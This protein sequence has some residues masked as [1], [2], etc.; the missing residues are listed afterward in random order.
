MG[1]RG[2]TTM[3]S[4]L[5]PLESWLRSLIREE[6]QAAMGQ[7]GNTGP[8]HPEATKPYF[9]VRQ[10][11]QFSCLGESTIRLAISKRELKAHK[12][13]ERVIIKRIDLERFL[14]SNPIE[15]LPY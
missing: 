9:T 5:G 10:A 3:D 12:V 2:E 6:I 11:A 7:N 8:K 1:K 14:E 4:P 15:A 13:G